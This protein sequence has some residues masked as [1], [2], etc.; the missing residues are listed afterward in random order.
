MET[1]AQILGYTPIDTHSHFDH[2]V[3]GDLYS[4]ASPAGRECHK[5]TLDFLCQKYDSVGI[6]PACFST[7]ASVSTNK[8]VAEE[9]R[10]LHQLALENDRIFQWVVVEPTQPET[11]DQAAEMLKSKKTIG[12]KIHPKL[13]EYDILEHGDKLFSFAN[14]IH[15]V[16]Q[17]HPAE[18]PQM[19]AFADK[20]PNMK[21]IIAHLGN[22]VFMDAVAKAKHGNIFV[23]TSG[24]ASHSNNVVERAVSRI[25]AEH[26]LFGT[27]G[28]SSAFQLARI[29][30]ADIS[31]EQ[32]KQ[33][34]RTNALN[35]FPNV[36][37]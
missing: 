28:Y 36:F 24:S 16:V 13:H 27:D 30:W 37:E 35:L 23:D 8:R 11:F 18:I 4:I 20:Y 29:A 9:N 10:Y 31:E 17:M 34:L 7:Y 5:I 25:G 15:A 21:L 32:K 22:D 19:P 26:I 33:I 6:G 12:I 14:D 2:G 1:I 3:E